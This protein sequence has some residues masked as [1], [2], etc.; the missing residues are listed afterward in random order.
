MARNEMIHD[1]SR[2]DPQNRR[3]TPER[4]GS[5]YWRCVWIE[6]HLYLYLYIYIPACS[7]GC[8]LNL[9]N[10]IWA[11]L[12]IDSAPF[13][14]SSYTYL[15]FKWQLL[16][17]EFWPCFFGGNGWPSKIEI[18]RDLAKYIVYWYTLPETNI[19]PEN[20]WL[21]DDPFLLGPGL[22]LGAKC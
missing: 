22:F 14:R 15:E 3:S 1:L 7:K 13:G 5:L 9:R 8:C 19:A 2:F 10:G 18:I 12:I 4:R 6:K 16:G 21:E 20:G 17:L 11:P